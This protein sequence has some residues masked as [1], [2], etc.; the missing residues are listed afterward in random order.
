MK[1]VW[2]IIEDVPYE[3]GA[4]L[5]VYATEELAEEALKYWREGCDCPE[6]YKIQYCEVRTEVKRYDT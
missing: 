6:F 4:L 3:S 5:D 1:A 2:C